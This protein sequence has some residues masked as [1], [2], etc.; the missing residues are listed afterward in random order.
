MNIKKSSSFWKRKFKIILSR[1]FESVIYYI[2]RKK[3]KKNF[4]KKDEITLVY[5][6][7]KVGSST[8]YNSINR[9]IDINIPI[10]HIHSLAPDKIIE[11]KIYYKN[12][13]R[14]SVPL[15]LLQSS[16]ISEELKSYK[17]KINIFTLI[18]EPISREMS[19]IFQDSFNFT[20]QRSMRGEGIDNIVE[21]KIK[22]M[23]KELPEYK[24]FNRELKY[25]FD[26]DVFEL[27]F[28]TNVG[29]FYEEYGN[30]KFCLIRLENLNNNFDAIIKKV[31]NRDSS[32]P[33]ISENDAED[34]FYSEDYSNLKSR[35]SIEELDLNKIINSSFVVKFYRDYIP[36]I[37]QKWLNNEG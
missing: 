20:N 27:T 5:S 21:E 30:K 35:L 28:N 36:S 9:S 12:S 15:H 10:Y 14:K 4:S 13:N 11:Q 8:I 1:Y 37:K 25:V 33:L 34:K 32:I 29:Y 31:F 23:V 3:I 6:I 18:R 17:G 7:G 19:S 22:D 24:W 16:A 2:E 26:I